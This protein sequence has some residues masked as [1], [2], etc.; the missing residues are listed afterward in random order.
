MSKTKRFEIEDRLR[1]GELKVVVTSSS[2]ELGI[3][4][5]FI[6]L[7]ILLRSPKGVARALQRL[8]R[9]GHKLHD[10]PKGKFIVLD[11]DD[12]VECGMLMKYMI[13]RKIDRAEIPCHALDVLSQ[14]I[15]GMAITKVWKADEMLKLIRRSYCYRNL[16]KQDFFDVVSYLAGDYALEHRNVYAKI[17]YDAKTGEIG[18]RGKLARVIYMTNIGTIPEEGFI[19]VVIQSPI[20][21]K[22]EV[23]GSIDE[24][25]LERIKRGDVFVLGGAKYL[26]LY[27]RG[28]KAY[29]RADVSQNPTV[30]SWFSE[31]LPLSFDVAVG[32]GHF[33]ALVKERIRKP[34]ECIKFIQD[35]LYCEKQSADEVY[36]YMKEQADFSELPDD[37]LLVVEKF[38]GEKNYLVFHSMY[39][40]RVNDALS[41]AFGYVAGELRGRDVEI[42]I[43]DNGFYIASND[44]LNVEKILKGINSG[45]FESILKEAIEKTDVLKRRFR[46]CASR[47]LMILRNYKGRVKSVGRQQVHSGFLL[48]AVKKISNEFPILREARREV[49]EDV[50]DVRNALEI[51]KKMEKGEVK[52]KVINVPLV[53]PFGINLILQSHTDL[54]KLEDKAVFLKRMHELHMGIIKEKTRL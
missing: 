42:G 47:S 8:G 16:T 51:L 18:K 48:A 39:G 41:R 35:Y 28:M 7:V 53:S 52:V 22:G 54:I 43:N 31:M 40:R 50:M 1:K 23:I 30:P 36:F 38:K 12:L 10:N 33:R 24:A 11:R 25:F 13:E 27:S 26:F 37:K 20:G 2:L 19:E 46:H 44:E 4:I 5:G 15:F 3:D 17:W 45:N 14:H 9:S 6:D 32:I 49:L 29:V 21:R 34:I